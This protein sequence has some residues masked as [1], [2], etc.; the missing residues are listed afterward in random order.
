MKLIDLRQTLSVSD[1]SIINFVHSLGCS[2][3]SE[4]RVRLS[5]SDYGFSKKGFAS[6]TPDVLER[7]TAELQLL[8]AGLDA[9]ALNKLA[10]RI[11]VSRRVCLVGFGTSAYVAQIIS[12][13]LVRLGVLAFVPPQ[14][15]QTRV[16]SLL[17]ENDTVLAV[18][19]S[20]G[21]DTVN[22]AVRNAKD[23]GATVT[24]MTSFMESELVSLC[25]IVLYLDTTEAKNGRFPL[26]SRVCQLAAAEML[27]ARIAKNMKIGYEQEEK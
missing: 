15:E 8:T 23:V 6:S 20:G 2:G 17:G 22:R 4:F 18:S 9:D 7:I 24:C 5:Q 10:E 12:G 11:A 13:Y 14:E 16:C 25:D 1:G 26:V 21:T 27:L 19:F 3:Y